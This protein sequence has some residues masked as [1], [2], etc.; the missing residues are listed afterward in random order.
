MLANRASRI[1]G[2]ALAEFR[3]FHLSA[4]KLIFKSAQP[5]SYA[6]RNNLSIANSANFFRFYAK[7]FSHLGEHL[8]R[9]AED[10]TLTGAN[11]QVQRIAGA[12]AGFKVVKQCGGAL[13]VGGFGWG[14]GQASGGAGKF[15]Q[16]PVARSA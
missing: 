3:G 11:R 1:L 10:C 4:R 13:E 9:C 12:Q 5:E 6:S 8:V 15:C 7:H 14:E 16:A 2:H